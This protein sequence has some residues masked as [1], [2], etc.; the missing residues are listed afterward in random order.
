[1]SVIHKRS[2]Q[3]KITSGG[4]A[5][6]G[7]GRS[8]TADLGCEGEEEEEKVSSHPIFNLIAF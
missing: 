1:M 3:F 5:T 2:L 8:Y 4:S 6:D 7:D